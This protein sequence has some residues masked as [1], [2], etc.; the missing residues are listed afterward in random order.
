VSHL[1]EKIPKPTQ[2]NLFKISADSPHCSKFISTYRVTLIKDRQL[3]FESCRLNNSAQ[4]QPLIKSLIQTHGQSDSEQF[5]V[6]ML[7]GKN[8]I[9]GLN[10]V[11]TG[12]VSSAT[13]TPRELLKPAILSNSSALILAHNHPSGDI[14]PSPD[15]IAVTQRIVQASKIMGIVVHEHLIISIFDDRYYSFADNGI[16]KRIS[17]EIG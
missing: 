13:V 3:P 6:L 14:S 10:I 12:D 4:A 9:I 8:E 17:D 1:K 5:C 15:D 7:N 2:Q 11:S 16:I